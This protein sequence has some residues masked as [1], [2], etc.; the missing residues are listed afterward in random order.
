MTVKKVGDLG[1][2]GSSG[3]AVELEVSFSRRQ[4]FRIVVPFLVATVAFGAQNA[5]QDEAH[6]ELDD[7]QSG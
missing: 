1:K 6:D 3:H 7:S 5:I 2:P 4:I